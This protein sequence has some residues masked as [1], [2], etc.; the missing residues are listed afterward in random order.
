MIARILVI[1]DDPDDEAVLC[2]LLEQS[3]RP[4]T[5]VCERLLAPA[6]RRLT[7]ESFSLVFLDM[8]LPDSW[9]LE[10]LRRF[11]TRFPDVPVVLM[12]GAVLPELA[13]EAIAEGALACIFKHQLD[14]QKLQEILDRSCGDM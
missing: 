6:L 8:S 2:S 7:L 9:G 14:G 1:E 11:R 12:T 5:V 3:K 13:A 10:T 4:V